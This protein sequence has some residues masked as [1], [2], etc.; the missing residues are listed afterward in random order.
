MEKFLVV[1]RKRLS[2]SEEHSENRTSDSSGSSATMLLTQRCSSSGAAR[3]YQESYLSF[4]FTY[5]ETGNRELPVCVVCGEKLSNECMVPS[6][7]NRH[8]TTKHSHLEKKDKAYFSRLLSSQ[9]K[10]AKVMNNITKTS[11]KALVASYKVAEVIARKMQP[12]TAAETLILPACKEI[13]KSMLGEAAERE[14]SKVPLSND[15]IARRIE[16]MSADIQ[17]QVAEKL[18]YGAKFA[19]QLDES[20][21]ISK[22]CQLMSY[23]RF[24]N[25][26]SLAEQ[27]LACKEL[28]LTSTGSDINNCMTS[29]LKE[30]G[31]Y[32]KNCISVCTDGAPAMTGRMKGFTSR[33]KQDFPHIVFSHC[34]LHREALVAKTIPEG[35]KNVMSSVVEMVNYIKSRALKT[36]VL[37]VMC[38]EAGALHDT[39]ILHTEIRWLSRGKVLSRFYELKNEL[40]QMFAAEKPEFAA[41]IS[42]ETWCSKVA[43]LADIFGHL[44]ILNASMQG[45]E[46]NILSSSD[47]LNG[48][49]RKMQLW[50]SK[51]EKG[52]LE[53]F[54][55]TVDTDICSSVVLEHLSVLEDKMKQYFPSL[56]VNECDWVRNP[57]AV[58]TEDTKHLPLQE[59]EELAELQADRT[60][61]LKFREE[62]LLQ[63]WIL[64]KREFPVLSEHAISVLLPFST[65]YLCEQGFS[66]LTYIKNK[67]RERLLSVDQE[68]RVCLSAIPPRIEQLCR[69]KQAHVSH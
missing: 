48:F 2:S 44:N 33:L 22:K 11:E 26:E 37:K 47:K 55:L 42:D 18:N 41:L 23:V 57:F 8:L 66:A 4:G 45:K 29:T 65:T 63:F 62:T 27:F 6:K 30:N 9:V 1:K 38:Q 17:K 35:L 19:L 39:L 40:L 69:S 56:N 7:L 3:R 43:Y 52:E 21:D 12:H 20:T 5:T 67:K 46:E 31:L 14:I 28:P 64:V 13:V 32:W 58:T 59:A 10:E 16:D 54:P 24:L 61:K 49:L 51:V 60:M 53:M 50:K 34:F 36:R 25:G 15:T 68:L